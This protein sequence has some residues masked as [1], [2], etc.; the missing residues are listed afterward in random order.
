MSRSGIISLRDRRVAQADNR[1][2]A[3]KPGDSGVPVHL[4]WGRD[5]CEVTGRDG[6]AE[7]EGASNRKSMKAWR[8]AISVHSDSSRVTSS[9]VIPGLM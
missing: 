4:G 5:T 9:S 1:G 8:L 3:C 7:G 6:A 2:P